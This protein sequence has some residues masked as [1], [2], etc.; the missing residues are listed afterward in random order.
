MN[1]KNLLCF[2][3]AIFCL[4]QIYAQQRTYSVSNAHAHND[5]EHPVPFYTAYDAGFGSIEADIF[6]RG[7]QLL[8]AHN[9]VDVVPEKTLQSLYL[10][11]LQKAI[12]ANKGFAYADSAKRLL[13]LIDIKTAATPTL[14]ALQQLLQQYKTLTG[15]PGLKIVIT[16]NQPDASAFTSY[17]SWLYFDG[18]LNKTYSGDALARVALFSHDLRKYTSWDGNGMLDDA[19]K[20]KIEAAVTKAHSLNK[21]IRFWAAP[22]VPD[23]W[24]QLM[25]LDV[26]YLNTD[27]ISAIAEFLKQQGSK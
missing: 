21:P 26:D 5:Y 16:G 11:P 23:A 18:D 15:C 8:V 17:P 24:R 13:L 7:N 12:T 1:F 20:K 25:Q 14:T 27:K 6:L 4:A 10:E 9:A 19:G 22:D 3:A 2:V